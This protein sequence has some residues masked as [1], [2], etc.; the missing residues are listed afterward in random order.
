MYGLE[1]T[2]PGMDR[3]HQTSEIHMSFI[4]A[5]WEVV[6]SSEFAIKVESLVEGRHMTVD[7]LKNVIQVMVREQSQHF[8][9]RLVSFLV[10]VGIFET[11]FG[12]LFALIG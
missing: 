1:W 9:I 4:E 2:D 10:L 6:V 5:L 11:L 7:H 3:F 12:E 8:R